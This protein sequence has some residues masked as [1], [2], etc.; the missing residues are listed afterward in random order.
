MEYTI[1][2]CT[3]DM[4]HNWNVKILLNGKTYSYNLNDHDYQRAMKEY[5]RNNLKVAMRLLKGDK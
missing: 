4:F 2:A 5:N 1:L 3:Q